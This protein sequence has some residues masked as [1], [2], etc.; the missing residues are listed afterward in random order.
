MRPPCVDCRDGRHRR[1]T[2]LAWD[3]KAEATVMCPCAGNM[4]VSQAAVNVLAVLVIV[5][6]ALY[7]AG[8]GTLAAVVFLR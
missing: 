3:A 7:A 4:H 5:L 6:G 2:G 8:L 1:C